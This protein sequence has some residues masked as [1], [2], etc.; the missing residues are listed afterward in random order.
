MSWGVIT[1]GVD[2]LGITAGWYRWYTIHTITQC[3]PLHTWYFIYLCVQ[4]S[5]CDSQ[6]QRCMIW[7]IWFDKI[8]WKIL[9]LDLVFFCFFFL[10]LSS[11]DQ[12]DPQVASTALCRVLALRRSAPGSGRRQAA[13]F[14]NNAKYPHMQNRDAIRGGEVKPRL[15]SALLRRPAR[16]P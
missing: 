8:N 3:T 14:G 9:K 4:C 10:V 16:D 5:V 15:H 13:G 12:G 11:E 1:V 2:Y 7:H 6:Y